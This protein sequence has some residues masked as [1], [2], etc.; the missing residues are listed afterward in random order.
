MGYNASFFCYDSVYLVKG[1]NR[2]YQFRSK[3]VNSTPAS[4]SAFRNSL[5]LIEH[6]TLTT[7]KFVSLD[8]KIHASSASFSLTQ[9]CSAGETGEGL[10]EC[11]QAQDP[12]KFR[13]PAERTQEY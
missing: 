8:E 12:L 3:P 2:T 11:R 13:G 5:S 9:S 7:F 1:Y 4:R 10:G 6:G